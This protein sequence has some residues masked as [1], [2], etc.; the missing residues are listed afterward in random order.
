MLLFVLLQAG[1]R[2]LQ[3]LCEKG[4]EPHGKFRIFAHSRQDLALRIRPNPRSDGGDGVT[5][6]AQREQ[7][8]LAVATLPYWPCRSPTQC[9]PRSSAGEEGVALAYGALK[10]CHRSWK[11]FFGHAAPGAEPAC[12]EGR[13]RSGSLQAWPA[14]S[15]FPFSWEVSTPEALPVSFRSSGSA[16]TVQLS[17][18]DVFEN[19]IQFG[20]ARHAQRFQLVRDRR[21]GDADGAPL[22]EVRLQFGNSDGLVGFRQDVRHILHG[23]FLDEVKRVDWTVGFLAGEFLLRSGHFFRGSFRACQFPRRENPAWRARCPFRGLL[24]GRELPASWGWPGAAE[25]P[26]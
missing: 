9:D 23:Q 24:R 10:S 20:T 13:R 7:G 14:S 4:H 1:P 22:V 2:G 15:L 3:L 18:E 21:K 19:L 12:M 6:V 25:T 5:L 26:P 16:A 8:C 17:G 11:L